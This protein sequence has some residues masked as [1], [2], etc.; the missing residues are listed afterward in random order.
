M[1]HFHWAFWFAYAWPTKVPTCHLFEINL[2]KAYPFHYIDTN[3]IL[4]VSFFVSVSEA[5]LSYS[6]KLSLCNLSNNA[7][8]FANSVKVWF[9]FSLEERSSHSRTLHLMLASISSFTEDKPSS[10][11]DISNKSFLLSQVRQPHWSSTSSFLVFFSK[12][13]LAISSR[14]SLCRACSNSQLLANSL[15]KNGE[16]SFHLC[17]VFYPK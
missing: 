4:D 11:P 7:W 14:L 1:R 6:F 16:K 5:K 8:E 15:L 17:V 10:R 3:C 13:R 9:K 12:A 2:K